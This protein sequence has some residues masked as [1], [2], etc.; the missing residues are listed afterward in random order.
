MLPGSLY[1]R[2]ELVGVGAILEGNLLPISLERSHESGVERGG[3]TLIVGILVAVEVLKRLIAVA[4]RVE[5]MY[6]GKIVVTGGVMER[7]LCCFDGK[8]QQVSADTR[9]RRGPA[10]SHS[11]DDVFGNS[12]RDRRS[13]LGYGS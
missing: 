2:S 10:L 12:P 4:N 1:L 13:T 9:S 11:E 7:R 6:F 5:G 8:F 3:R